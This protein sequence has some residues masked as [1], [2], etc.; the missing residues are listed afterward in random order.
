MSRPAVSRRREFAAQRPKFRG[1]YSRAPKQSIR[2]KP[3]PQRPRAA[4]RPSS[5][6]AAGCHGH[7]ARHVRRLSICG[8]AGIAELPVRSG[9]RRRRG[10]GRAA[11]RGNDGAGGEAGPTPEAGAEQLSRAGHC[12]LA[13]TACCIETKEAAQAYGQ[14]LRAIRERRALCRRLTAKP[15]SWPP[16]GRS[17]RPH[18]PSSIRWPRRTPASR[19]HASYLGLAKAQAGQAREAIAMWR[20]L[21][22]DSPASSSLAA[23]R[24]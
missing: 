19:G 17:R 22:I 21:E 24:P 6:A 23:V 9:P 3:R 1:R 2:P 12:S 18:R 15:S 5:R 14:T 7:P 16:T 10:E 8:I 4:R 20:S 11:S 13:P